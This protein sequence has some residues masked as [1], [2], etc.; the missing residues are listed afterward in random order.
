VAMLD[1]HNNI[2]H[3][4][5]DIYETLTDDDRKKVIFLQEKYL[6]ATTPEPG[7]KH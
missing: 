5:K 2:V 1:T 7:F 6:W 3:Y 4:R